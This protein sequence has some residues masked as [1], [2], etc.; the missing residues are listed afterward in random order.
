MK[1]LLILTALCCCPLLSYGQTDGFMKLY[2]KYSGREGYTT[3]EMAGEMFRAINDA[4]GTD[5]GAPGLNNVN[6][7]IIIVAETG[8]KAFAEE[9]KAVLQS[10][11]YA[12]VS[13]VHDG[14]QSVEFFIRQ[15]EGN[16]TEV[17][18]NVYDGTEHIVMLLDGYDLNI[19]QI[20]RITG[21]GISIP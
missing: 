16:T 10:G 19:S 7:M 17:V 20:S 4:D 5:S 11:E 6:R 2:E 8:N 14:S 15:E 1:K 3:V 18:M 21:P 12:T 9:V 13:A